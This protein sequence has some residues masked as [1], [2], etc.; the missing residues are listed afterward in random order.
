MSAGLWKETNYIQIND[1]DTLLQLSNY[2]FDGSVFDIYGAL[3]NGARLVMMD[4]DLLLI[5]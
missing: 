1:T 5:Q 2:A 3:L 4:Q